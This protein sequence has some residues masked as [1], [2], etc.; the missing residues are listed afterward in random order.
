MG[1]TNNL[2]ENEGIPHYA[3]PTGLSV[4]KAI[5]SLF[6]HYCKPVKSVAAVDDKDAEISM[7]GTTF[8]KFCRDCP[9]L[10]KRVGRT[11]VDLIFS[12]SKPL[13]IRRLGYE[14]FLDA[15]LGLAK[16]IYPDE[17]P[18]MAFASLLSQVCTK[19]RHFSALHIRSFLFT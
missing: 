5:Y 1:D 11:N 19:H 13:G 7:D 10:G 18:T 9:H 8:A 15:L 12:K 16:T 3:P 4:H 2:P 14:Q 17:E 6:E